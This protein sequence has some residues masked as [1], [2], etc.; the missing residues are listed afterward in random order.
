MESLGTGMARAGTSSIL[1]FLKGRG[2][3]WVYQWAAAYCLAELSDLEMT[4]TLH[5]SLAWADQRQPR[6]FEAGGMKLRPATGPESYDGHVAQGVRP[7]VFE[8]L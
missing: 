7:T 8:C 4:D 3:G 2:A 5:S 6:S 1:I